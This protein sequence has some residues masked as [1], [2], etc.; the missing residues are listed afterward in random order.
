MAEVIENKHLAAHFS[1]ITWKGGVP[2]G[3]DSLTPPVLRWGWPSRDQRHWGCACG[4]CGRM[5]G[6]AEDGD[7]SLIIAH[8][9]MGFW[10]GGVF[11]QDK[12]IQ[13]NGIGI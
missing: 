12:K 3:Q 7:V 9:V 5:C 13:V 4:S 2:G 1:K 10:E 6:E 11:G 8:S